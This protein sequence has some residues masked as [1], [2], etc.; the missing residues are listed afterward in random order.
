MMKL[1]FAEFKNSMLREF[2][3]TDLGRMSFFL[4]IEVLQRSDGIYIC[5]R[6][7]ALEV[8]KRFR[9]ENNNSVHNPIFP[10]CK[11][12][13]D[14]NGARVDETQFK[15]M[16]GCLMYITATR[17]D[18]MFAV[19]LISRY[20]AKPTELHLMAAK[21]IL[22]Y[23]KGTIGLGVFYKKRGR[24]G[25]IA[26]V[27]SNYVGDIEDMK[28]TSGF[29]FILGYGALAWSS[30][31]KTIVTLSTI[32]AKFVVAATCASQAVWMKRIIEKLNPEEIE[33]LS[34]GFNAHAVE[35]H[36]SEAY[37]STDE[38]IPVPVVPQFAPGAPEELP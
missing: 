5:Q 20:M 15:Q 21:R 22:R 32:E 1:M 25:L 19:S 8:L 34:R 23:F 31:K 37:A 24:E 4:G 2:D 11:S 17:P 30:R 13:K 12:F 3:V 29:V 6:K 26:Y 7:Y 10:G 14:E 33:F 9:M 16:V 35:G 38:P 18:F 36:Y 28:T 27:D